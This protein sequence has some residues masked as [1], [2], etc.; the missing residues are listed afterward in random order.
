MSGR[1]EAIQKRAGDL[2]ARSGDDLR[3]ARLMLGE[4]SPPAWAVAF[5]AQQAAEKAIKAWLTF[6]EIDFAHT[7]DIRLL[8]EMVDPGEAWATRA[9][10]AIALSAYATT[11][12][13]VIHARDITREQGEEALALAELVVREATE[14]LRSDGRMA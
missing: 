12:R 6:H 14:A 3:I 11:S 7:H 4:A 10:P 8:L 13:Y 9:R 1:R 5:H 2:L